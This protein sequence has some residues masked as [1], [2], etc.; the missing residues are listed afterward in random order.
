MTRS[1]KEQA[2]N[3]P[4][5]N[6]KPELLKNSAITVVYKT[7]SPSSDSKESKKSTFSTSHSKENNTKAMEIVDE[8][9]I[10]GNKIK[11]EVIPLPKDEPFGVGL[12][13]PPKKL[14]QITNNEEN[15]DDLKL[16]EDFL[17]EEDDEGGDF[18]QEVVEALLTT[19][20]LLVTAMEDSYRSCQSLNTDNSVRVQMENLEMIQPSKSNSMSS[21]RKSDLRVDDTASSKLK[22]KSNKK[23]TK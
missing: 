22:G 18:T 12:V 2:N 19:E 17:M 7:E 13:T 9:T 8:G 6:L 16:V 15:E 5:S 14:S 11:D 20:P 23:M 3:T 10:D 21:K 4:N 1:P